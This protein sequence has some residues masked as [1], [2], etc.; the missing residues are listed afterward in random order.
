M[1]IFIYIFLVLTSFNKS[2]SQEL[3]G[4][5]NTVEITQKWFFDHSKFKELERK[6]IKVFDKK[7]RLIKDIEFG[8]HHNTNLKLIGNI[9]TYEFQ[10]NKLISEKTYGSEESFKNN[11][12]Q[13]YWN[14]FYNKSK[15]KRVSSNHSN[16]VYTY[17]KENKLIEW[18][19]KNDLGSRKF[20]VKY[21][22]N[23]N[24]IERGEY[25][26]WTKKYTREK[27]T[28]KIIEYSGLSRK[29]DTTKT[30]V[31]EVYSKDKI[32]YRKE[33]GFGINTKKYIYFN[34]GN[35]KSVFTRVF[36]ETERDFKSELVYYPNGFIRQIRKYEL[37]E[38]AWILKQQTEFEI[39][40][41]VSILSKKERKKTNEILINGNK[42]WLQQWL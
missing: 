11:Q 15:L 42:N 7:G 14:Y 36:D 29:G 10:K 5:K 21:D 9:R 25:G 13:F 30:Y 20:F 34:N 41:T 24:I 22:D 12:I 35:L 27:D 23:E 37:K 19:T 18:T 31:S 39:N 8:F 2:F 38:N 16:Y 40:G 32:I 28:I 3:F 33:D 26:N 1:R 17:D 6:E 4:Q